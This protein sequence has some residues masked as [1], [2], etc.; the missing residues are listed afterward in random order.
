MSLT[1][2]MQALDMSFDR[3]VFSKEE[4]NETEAL[5]YRIGTLSS[6]NIKFID[7]IIDLL[8]EHEKD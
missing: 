3:F 7:G 6:K 1:R 2:I 8:L 5:T 4:N